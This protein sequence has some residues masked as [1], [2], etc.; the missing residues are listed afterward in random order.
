MHSLHIDNTVC[1]FLR[2]I[3]LQF[4]YTSPLMN[5]NAF[6]ATFPSCPK[7]VYTEDSCILNINVN[8]NAFSS[9]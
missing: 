2:K 1:L 7:S 5:A 4:V 3:V 6:L 8:E 9:L